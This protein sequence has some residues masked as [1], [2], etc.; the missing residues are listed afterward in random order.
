MVFC[1]W[2]KGVE[3]DS[4]EGEICT[5]ANLVGEKYSNAEDLDGVGVLKFVLVLCTG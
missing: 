1:R 4:M 3:G 2:W 5:G